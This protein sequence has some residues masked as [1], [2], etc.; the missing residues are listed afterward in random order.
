VTGPPQDVAGVTRPVHAH[1]VPA[2]GTAG[3]PAGQDHVTD[4]GHGGQGGHGGPA[5]TWAMAASATLHCL[6]GCAIGEV[7]GMVIGTWLGLHDLATI[8]LA[9]A[10][11]FCFGYALTMRGVLRAGVGLRAALGVALAADT[12]SIT[13]MEVVDNAVVLAIPGAMA[14]GLVSALFWGSLALGFAVAFVLTTPVNRWLITRG[15]GHAVVHAY[16]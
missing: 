2:Q 15:R 14:A 7:L 11:A 3:G 4:G 6:T 5:A 13:V 1:R 8:A 10:L 12:V 9:V 16:H